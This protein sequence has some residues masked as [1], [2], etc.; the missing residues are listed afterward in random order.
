MS[1]DVYLY[2]PEQEVAC[3]CSECGHQHTRKESACF[4]TANITHNLGDMAD[5]AGIYKHLWRPEELGISTAKELI[6][7]L[8]D[9]IELLE[10]DPDLFKKYDSPNGWGM[11]EHFVPFVI[12]YRNACKKYPG[13]RVEVWR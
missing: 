5:A 10:S 7:P 9:G 4:Y 11:Y 6:A 1:L 2:G 12:E 3:V 13:A 8:T